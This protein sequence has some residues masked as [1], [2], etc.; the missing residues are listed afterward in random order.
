MPDKLQHL[1]RARGN[2]SL[3]RSLDLEDGIQVD[4]AIT[5]LF[6]S[7]LHYIDSFLAGKNLHARGHDARDSEVSVNGTLSPIYNDYRRLKDASRAA[8][9]DCVDYTQSHF[10][11]FD[12]RFRKI[13]D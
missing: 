9:Y 3:V 7:A 12:A 13:K 2:E 4:W 10:S 11:Q 8:R 5:M 1:E 6:Y